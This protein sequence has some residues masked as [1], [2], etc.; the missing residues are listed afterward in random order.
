MREGKDHKKYILW[1]KRTGRKVIT[2][3]KGQGGGRGVRGLESQD[4]GQGGGEGNNCGGTWV[5]S[6]QEKYPQ[7]TFGGNWPKPASY[8]S[9]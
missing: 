3:E 9:A 5:F 1:K 2:R 4:V 8:G 7:K 6:P